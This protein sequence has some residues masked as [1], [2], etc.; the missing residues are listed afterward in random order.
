MFSETRNFGFRVDFRRRASV[1]P[2]KLFRA[3]RGVSI[4]PV[5]MF[6]IERPMWEF[7]K[8]RIRGTLFWGPYNKDPTILGT[9]LG[10]LFS[11]TP[12]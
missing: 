2:L 9:T 4:L 1:Q 7:P 11:E 5:R 10:S 3:Y 12:M 6:G 8:I